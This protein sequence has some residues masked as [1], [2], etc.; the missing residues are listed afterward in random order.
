MRVLEAREPFGIHSLVFTS[1]PDPVPGPRDVLVQLKALSLN[2]RDHL[3][4]DGAG[5]WR[6]PEP[7]I[8]VSDGVGVVVDTGSAVSRFAKGDRV[9]AIFYPKWIDGPPSTEKMEG[10]LGGAGADGVYAEYVVVDETAAAI[11]PSHLSDEEAATLPCAGVT[12]WNAVAEGATL[13]RGDTVVVLGTGGVALF[14]LQFAKLAGARVIITSSSDAK[15]ARAREL[16]AD[17]GVNYRTTPDWPRAVR[18]LTRGEGADLVVDTAGEFAAAIDAVRVGGRIA[19]VGLLRG[20]QAD[21][22]LVKLMGSSATI[23]A[24]D[25]GSRAMFEAMNRT[26]ESARI[27]PVID[28][29]FA[30][31]EARDAFR[32]LRQGA[33]FG[34]VCIR[35]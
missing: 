20:T 25:V 16:G 6:P 21:V 14:A 13:R 11:V 7:R 2:Y 8:P 3:V 12:A 1:R 17:D 34:K 31:D 5:R 9:A 18:E 33:H 27:R 10:S 23:R 28:R 29:T 35:V 26:V 4:I 30:F 22:D 24:I 32:Y 15:L 19:F